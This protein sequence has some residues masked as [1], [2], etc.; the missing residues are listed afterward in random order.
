MNGS[1]MQFFFDEKIRTRRQFL[2]SGLAAMTG[3]MALSVIPSR[4]SISQTLDAANQSPVRFTV[5]DGRACR[6]CRIFMDRFIARNRSELS[7]YFPEGAEIFFAIG[8]EHRNLPP[9]TIAVGKCT[10]CFI[11]KAALYVPGCL[12]TEQNLRETIFRA[13]NEF[14]RMENSRGKTALLFGRG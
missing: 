10:A 9:R 5:L 7:R 14:G 1:V 8:K 13:K 12:P 6:P 2:R 11:G 4:E 3:W